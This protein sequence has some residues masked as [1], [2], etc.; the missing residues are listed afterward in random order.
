MRPLR[1]GA[2]VP[3]G[4]CWL[5]ERDDVGVDLGDQAAPESEKIA[6]GKREVPVL[7]VM[8]SPRTRYD[9]NVAGADCSFDGKFGAALERRILN[10]VVELGLATRGAQAVDMP[11]DIVGETGENRRVV[12]RSTSS[13][14]T[15]TSRV[16]RCIW[17]PRSR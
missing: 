3:G 12:A 16:T 7:A 10:L 13:S 6:V 1:L 15:R 11:H 4:G 8:S 17:R 5:S 9:D 14:S 2:A